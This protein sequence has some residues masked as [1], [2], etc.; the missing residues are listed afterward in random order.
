MVHKSMQLEVQAKL[1]GIPHASLGKTA[2]R[3]ARFF[4]STLPTIA[5]KAQRRGTQNAHADR[6]DDELGKGK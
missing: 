6:R 5:G 1:A 2:E 3:Q 4:K